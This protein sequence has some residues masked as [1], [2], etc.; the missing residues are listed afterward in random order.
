MLEWFSID[1]L[2][3]KAKPMTHQLDYSTNIK[4]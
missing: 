4:P 2:K 1:C 3:T